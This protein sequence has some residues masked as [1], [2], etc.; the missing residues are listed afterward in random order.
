MTQK[1]VKTMEKVPEVTC[2]SLG[3]DVAE[4]EVVEVIDAQPITDTEKIV[5]LEKRVFFLTNALDSLFA[6]VKDIRDD[7]N[8]ESDSQINNVIEAK[9]KENKVEVPEG[10]VLTGKTSG[11]SY[12]LQVRNGGFY[13]GITRYDSLSAA[14]EGVS[15]VRRSG[16]TFWKLPDGKTVKEV[17]KE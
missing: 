4:A 16:W 2:V 12:F 6:M 17:F 11:L 15:G 3:E 1:E 13:V 10:T 7:T 9:K 14:A 8:R 5:A